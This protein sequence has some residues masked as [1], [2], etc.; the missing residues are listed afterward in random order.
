MCTST[1]WS[2]CL[3]AV[4]SNTRNG[5]N[6]Q[7][8]NAKHTVSPVDNLIIP[9]VVGKFAPLQ[10]PRAVE[11]VS[12]CVTPFV[13]RNTHIDFVRRS[14]TSLPIERVCTVNRRTESCPRSPTSSMPVASTKVRAQSRVFVSV[15]V[16]VCAGCSYGGGGERRGARGG[17]A[18][19]GLCAAVVLGAQRRL[20][21]RRRHRRLRVGAGQPLRPCALLRRL[22]AA[23]HA[24]AARPVQLPA[25][26]PGL[27]AGAVPALA[28]ARL[29]AA[30]DDRS[31][32]RTDLT[33]QKLEM[34]RGRLFCRGRSRGCSPGAGAS[35]SI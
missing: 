32:V 12:C 28:H 7:I 26:P 22:V 3:A 25:R 19:Q 14:L 18:Q 15:R 27:A 31:A 2:N 11:R 23:S 13:L 35:Y 20:G 16:E 21:C 1:Y 17:G 4:V 9:T 33:T 30:R 34:S 24:P 8:S 5:S 29:S 10:R 6:A